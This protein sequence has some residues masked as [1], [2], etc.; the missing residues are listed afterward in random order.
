LVHDD[1][2]QELAR[3]VYAEMVQRLN[4]DEQHATLF[5]HF[6]VLHLSRTKVD[7]NRPLEGAVD[8]HRQGDLCTP[9]FPS[10]LFSLAES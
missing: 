9:L 8:D 10:L 6:V 1:C 5:P 3:A 4:Q 7:V 2:S